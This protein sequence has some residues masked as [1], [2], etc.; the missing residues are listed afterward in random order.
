[1]AKE[2]KYTYEWPRPMVTVDAVVFAS[3]AGKNEVLLIERKNEPFKGQWAV[4]GGLNKY[5]F[6][7][8]QE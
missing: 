5:G 8:P 7:L 1:M 2:G 4:P 3:S 6:L